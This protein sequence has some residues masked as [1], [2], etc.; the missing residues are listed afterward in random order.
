[1]KPGRDPD[2]EVLRRELRMRRRNVMPEA[3][4]AAAHAIATGVAGLRL[5]RPGRRVGV[6]LPIGGEVDT[7][8]VIALARR[9]GCRVFAPVVTSFARRSMRFVP[10]SSAPL[11]RNRWGIPEPGEGVSVHGRWLDVVLVP[12]VAFDATGARLGMGAGFYDRHFAYLN[13]RRS[14]RRPLLVGL[15]YEFQRVERLAQADWDV[16]LAG[17]VTERGCYGVPPGQ[18][19]SNTETDG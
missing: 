1:M 10:L 9:Q 12:C 15:A 4:Q 19:C 17:V 13:R 14:W 8:P 16:R 18:D 2:R 6:Y 11:M 5:F 3:R 7:E